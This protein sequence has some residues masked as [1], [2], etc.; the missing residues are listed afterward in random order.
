MYFGHI[1]R[2]NNVLKIT[3]EGKRKEKEQGVERGVG[4]ENNIQEWTGH[5]LVECII[6]ARE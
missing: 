4:W 6:K 1:K 3:L 2:H 5:I